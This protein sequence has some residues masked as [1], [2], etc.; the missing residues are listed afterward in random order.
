M[1]EVVSR[2]GADRCEYDAEDVVLWGLKEYVH[3][4]VGC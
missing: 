3:G 2:S 1:E 4:S